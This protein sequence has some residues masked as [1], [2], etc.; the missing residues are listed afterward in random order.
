MSNTYK[1]ALTKSNA[2]SAQ[3]RIAQQAY[4][5]RTI[6]DQEFLAAKSVHDIAC[7]LFDGAF[8][9]EE[10][11]DAR[12]LLDEIDDDLYLN[13]IR[14]WSNVEGVRVG[15][16]LKVSENEY[17][18]FTHDWGDSIQTTCGKGHPCAG[19]ASFH[20]FSH[21]RLQFSGSLAPAI[22][23]NKLIETE[24]IKD[25]SMWFFHHDERKANNSV[26]TTLPCRVYTQT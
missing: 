1:L 19:N 11:L 14:N 21:G 8:E 4:R 12:K 15:D 7:K 10:Q 25:G 6:G 26:K 16:F 22:P 24:E 5:D 2:A 17:L 20:A 23:K 18:R 3:F 13:I 9:M